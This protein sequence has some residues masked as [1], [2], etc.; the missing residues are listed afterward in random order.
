MAS[1]RELPRYV[2]FAGLPGLL[3]AMFIIA[4]PLWRVLALS[5]A[6]VSRFGKVRGFV[7]LENYT[8]ILTDYEFLACVVRSLVWT[9]G[10]VGGT[11]FISIPV[12][13]ILAR[14]FY[15][16]GLARVI[17]MLPWAVS[18]TMMAIIWRWI[19]NGEFGMLN[20]SL[21][22]LGALDN[23]V[24][25]LAEA[26]TAFPLQI[27]IGVLV[28]V[29]FATTILLGGLSSVPDDLYEA[30]AI[31]GASDWRQHLTLTLPLLRPFIKIAI[32]LNV[33]YVFNS[34]P[35]IWV[36]TQGGPGNGT[37][38]LVTY[39]YKLAFRF[40]KMGDAAVVSL[41]MFILLMGLTW[42][43]VKLTT[44]NEPAQA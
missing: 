4:Y 21:R 18:L 43:Y 6:D 20:H 31:E 34:F 30:A 9:A 27:M 40:G 24:V 2:L 5:V 14:D 12:A 28:S 10:V 41:A 36:T 39:L 33:I 3:L 7:G 22:G 11:I 1:P 13:I 44:K 16:R 26:A 42:L 17:V 15:G 35:I 25:W 8:N 37:D 38:I 29:P 32:V 19:L 23:N